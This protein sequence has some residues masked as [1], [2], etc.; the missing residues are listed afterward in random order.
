MLALIEMD[1]QSVLQPLCGRGVNLFK[2]EA[3]FREVLHFIKFKIA[4]TSWRLD[5]ELKVQEQHLEIMN[6]IESYYTS[7]VI[8]FQF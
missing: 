7:K 8:C 6:A 4:A 2:R 3:C 1:L 5:I